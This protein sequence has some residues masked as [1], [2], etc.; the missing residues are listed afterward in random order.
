MQSL[1][2][3][4]D[5]V[6]RALLIVAATVLVCCVAWQVLSRY[7]MPA[8]SVIT[9]EIGRFVLMWFSPP[10]GGGLCARPTPPSG[11]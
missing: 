11:H 2:K 7:V 3:G 4:A 6:L 10:A 8:P 1:I 9:D 5:A